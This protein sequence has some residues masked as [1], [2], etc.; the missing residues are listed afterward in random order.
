MS[1]EFKEESIEDRVRA[2]IKKMAYTK[3][4]SP[5][6]K[7]SSPKRNKSAETP[8]WNGMRL[9]LYYYDMPGKAEALRLAL[10]YCGIPFEDFRFNGMQ[11]FQEMRNSG[12]LVF[13]QVPAMKITPKNN[14]KNV[15]TLTQSAALLRFIAKLNPSMEL[16]PSD[17]ILAA[18]ADALIDEEVDTFT[19]WRT[20]KYPSRFG[21]SFLDDAANEKY[22]KK[23][24][25]DLIQK[26]I[27]GHL[28]KLE[29]MMKMGGTQ[30]LAGTKKP[31]IAD[32]H[33]GPALKSLSVKT[34]NSNFLDDFPLL[35]QMVKNFYEMFKPKRA[36][37]KGSSRTKVQRKKRGIRFYP[38]DQYVKKRAA[39][40]A[41]HAARQETSS[42]SDDVKSEICTVTKRIM[43]MKI[44]DSRKKEL[45]KRFKAKIKEDKNQ[46]D[47]K[48]VNVEDFKTVKVIGR[49]A[50]GEVRVVLKKDDD[51]V[52][53]MKT[54]RK[55]E[56]IDADHVAHIKAERDLLSAADNPWLVR[57]LYSFQDDIYLYLVMEY[58]GGGDLMTILMRED[59]LTIPQARFY[60]SELACAINSVHELKFVHR[61]LKPDNVL[62]ANTGHIKLSDFGLAKSL[63]TNGE[64]FVNQWHGES[65]KQRNANNSAK[66]GRYK[67]SRKMMYSTVGTPD[68]IAPEVFLQKGYA[69]SVDWWSLGVIL[70][71]CLVGYPPFYADKP[72]QTCKKIV[73]FRKTFRI[74]SE[75]NLTGEAKDIIRKLI[76]NPRTRLKYVGIVKHPFFRECN[77]KNLMVHSP[78]FQP[79][80]SSKVDTSNFDDFDTEQS[81]PKKHV[82]T[83]GADQN[84]VFQDFTFARREKPKRKALDSIFS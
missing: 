2:R 66:R 40:F 62:I 31:T 29:A 61:D 39:E 50:F 32:F 46:E 26:I 43:E 59:I 58:C 22:L 8:Y 24:R 11:E 80:L 53:A 18:K 73:N 81:L 69:E 1:Q 21:L 54:M 17:P 12:E 10:K 20:T 27:P 42:S 28:A 65:L 13:G 37:G 41:A 35:L 71:E 78:P 38:Y 15:T 67:R 60:I 45:I 9:K 74:P 52:Y 72:V 47:T 56:M 79:D 34:G 4:V 70:Y 84:K 76:C 33:W 75:A 55:K 19:G 23:A 51:K 36:K 3:K 7:D 30:W 48:K 64:D 16:Y 57:L 14:P 5:R 77:W 83:E 44:D 68:Y 6:P 63:N 82:K 25:E 49:G